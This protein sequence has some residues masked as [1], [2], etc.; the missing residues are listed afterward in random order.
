MVTDKS[1]SLSMQTVCMETR[2][3]HTVTSRRSLDSLWNHTLFMKGKL[4]W[5]AIVIVVS[6]TNV[7]VQIAV[8]VMVV[9][10]IAVQEMPP[11]PAHAVR[12]PITAHVRPTMTWNRM[13][14]ATTSAAVM[15]QNVLL[16]H[17]RLPTT[18]ARFR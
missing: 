4:I 18:V 16:D 17:I 8:Q 9:Q 10:V 7:Q 2:L 14:M 6:I 5:L 3:V 15:M 1:Y 13:M 11:V 12:F